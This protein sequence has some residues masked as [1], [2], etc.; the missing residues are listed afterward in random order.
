MANKTK[1]EERV[2]KQQLKVKHLLAVNKKYQS[3]INEWKMLL[4]V[5]EGIKQIKE[6]GYITKHEREPQ[7][8]YD[9]RMDELYGFGYSRSVIDIFHFYLF[10]KEPNRKLKPLQDDKLWNMFFDD[11]DLYGNSFDTTVSDV[12]LYAAILGHVGILVDMPDVDLLTKQE[13]IKNKVYPYMAKYFPHA[14][15]DWEMKRDRYSRPVLSMLKLRDDNG[16]FRIWWEDSWE[17]WELPKNNK[18]D[19]DT[20]NHEA[21]AVFINQGSNRIKVIPF[22]WHYNQR[23][24]DNCIGVSDIS[25]IARIDLSIIRNLSQ[26]EE[27]VNYAAFPMMLKPYKSADPKKTTVTQAEDEVSVQAVQEFDPEFPDA[28]PEWMK[29]EV[30]DPIEAILAFIEKKIAEIY[31]SSNAGGMAGTEVQTQAKSGVALKSEFQLLNSKLVSK[32]VNLELT[33]NKI[34]YYWLLWEGKQNLKDQ[35]S[36]ARERTFD[37]ENLTND[38][39]NALTAKTVVLSKRF[40][41]LL[42]KH[43]ARQTLPATSEDDM[44][45]IDEEIE[46]A[47][48]DAPD[49]VNEDDIPDDQDDKL[50]GDEYSKNKLIDPKQDT[51]IIRIK[52]NK[53]G[54]KTN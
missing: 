4:S 38:L 23:S 11:A 9:R 53:I 33:E 40:D 49:P 30:S 8:A 29:T 31:R 13:Q 24:K 16:Q 6:N 2:F 54:N 43:I 19:W 45:T 22:V 5:Y 17:V 27:I 1:K 21:D 32:A 46:K 15:L 25:E 44:A 50:A 7:E 52:V 37:L 51:S 20:S 3:F 18:G 26:T 47:V 41:V 28:K 35:L 14:I 34:V 12:S 36:I 48:A 42:Q 39:E 10:K